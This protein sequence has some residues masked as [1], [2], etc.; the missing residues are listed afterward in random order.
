MI[1]VTTISNSIKEK[2]FCLLI[3]H[4]QWRCPGSATLAFSCQANIVHSP[5]STT[6]FDRRPYTNHRARMLP[7]RVQ[8]KLPRFDKKMRLGRR[9]NASH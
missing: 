9:A 3:Q 5:D 2:P 7:N 6:K 4:L 1:T 8:R